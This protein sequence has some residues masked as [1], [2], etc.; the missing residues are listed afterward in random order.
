MDIGSLFK[1]RRTPSS[2]THVRQINGYHREAFLD[3]TRPYPEKIRF[4]LNQMDGLSFWGFALWRA[5]K[6]TD[7][8]KEIKESEVFMQCIGSSK[9]MLIEIRHPDPDDKT[10][11]YRMLVGKPGDYTGEPSETFQWDNNHQSLQVYS[12]E[13]FSADEAASILYGYFT[14]TSVAKYYR[15]RAIGVTEGIDSKP[16]SYD[17]SS[18]AVQKQLLNQAIIL[19][20]GRGMSSFPR[21]DEAVVRG[22]V[23][24]EEADE[25]LE[26]VKEVITGC[27]SVEIDWSAHSLSEAGDE[28]VRVMAQSYPDLNDAA[29]DALRWQFTYS[30][31]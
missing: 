11:A 6:D 31:K 26:K 25:L 5:P 18:T 4:T 7:F 24:K 14:S 29:L 17:V 28:A 2:A 27:M 16:E 10:T 1:K 19:Y 20:L 9:G 13:L 23:A 30:N 12:S 21:H 3:D 15:F 8:T 22:L